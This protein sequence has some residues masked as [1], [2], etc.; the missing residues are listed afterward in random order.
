LASSSHNQARL[1]GTSCRTETGPV[2][3]CLAM[4]PLTAIGLAGNVLAFV[5][6]GVKLVSKAHEIY[7][8]GSTEDDESLA[9][10]IRE[11]RDFSEK[12]QT[13]TSSSVVTP[14]LRSLKKVAAVCEDLADDLLELLEE[15]KAE[16]PKSKR[17]SA[18]AVWKSTWKRTE[19]E[20]LE[21]RLQRCSQL[22]DKELT[23]L[24]RYALSSL[25]RFLN[26]HI[27]NPLFLLH[28]QLLTMY[29][30]SKP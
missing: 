11:L 25:S 13:Q 15:F 27:A 5:D 23:N 2:P 9:F 6:F 1:R 30:D 29:P 10:V 19:K 12:L 21:S 3:V 26:A 14:E 28:N 24:S 18:K 16:N 7:N 4:D 20:D 22:L 8:K 17:Q